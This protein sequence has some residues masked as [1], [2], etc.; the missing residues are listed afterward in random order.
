MAR[1]LQ[2][3]LA[4][5]M[6]E[7]ERIARELHDTLLQSLFGLTLRFHTAA[8]RLPL[9]DPAREALDDALRQSDKVMQEGRER[10][11]N[12]R[13]RHTESA[14]LADLLA[15]IGNQLRAIHPANFQISVQGRP[16]PLDAI[17]Q[18]E[19]LLIGREALN[20]AFSHSGA[21]NIVAELSY[22]TT[23]LH[24]SINDDGR[25]IDEGV[26]QAGYRS[27]HWGLPGMRERANKMR[28]EL[29]VGRSRNGGTQIDLQVPAGIVYRAEDPIGPRP[30]NPFR[31]K[32]QQKS[33]FAAD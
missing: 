2:E 11:L 6:A 16:R 12:L 22:H 1:Q 19:I 21:Q 10:V 14:S 13:A 18:E 30:W 4:E 25:G 31:K 20:N 3:R 24:V 7:R 8:N 9:G 33:D 27:G 15:E 17:V 32:G 5:R 26:L 23:A 29:R 28:G